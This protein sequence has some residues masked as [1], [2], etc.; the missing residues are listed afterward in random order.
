MTRL[1]KKCLI[2]AAGSHL[3]VVVAILCSGFI[4]PTPK[5]DNT[6]IL[7]VIPANLVDKALNSGVP[8]PQTPPPSPTP[9]T[10]TPPAPT[11][12]PPTPTPPAP[13]PQTFVEKVEKMLTPD[14]TP[15]EKT[16]DE[17]PKAEPQKRHQVEVNL[18]PVVHTVSKTPDTSAQDAKEAKRLRDEHRKAVANAL[19]AIKENA[20]T[21]TTVELHGVSSASSASYSDA[22]KSIYYR[23]WIPP[24]NMS[25]DSA[26][27]GFSVTIARDG[28]V[29]S[30][31]IKAS[32][33]DADIDRAV[34]QMLDRVT[35]IAPFPE[36]AE[37][38]QRTY[39]IQFEATRTS[40]Q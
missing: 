32:S 7:D 34:Q 9:P 12:T 13:K 10:P 28:T 29:I 15:V 33:G 35:F 18:T 1:Q 27:V 39:P 36:G 23:K 5:T 21:A 3:L 26:T 11:P 6:T 17:Q 20:S 38:S 31:E 16:P 30:S 14:L 2:A 8:N 37:E 19:R 22:I 25:A 40:I 4:R 24:Q